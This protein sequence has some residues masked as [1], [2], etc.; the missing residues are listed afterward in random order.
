MAAP[1]AIL[2]ITFEK[3]RR[4]SAAILARDVTRD[5]IWLVEFNPRPTEYCVLN[6]QATV[7]L[8]NIYPAQLLVFSMLEFRLSWR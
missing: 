5:V 3:L 1:R 8:E 7:T 6:C 2:V 4:Y